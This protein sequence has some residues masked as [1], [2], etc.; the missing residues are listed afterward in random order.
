M[1]TGSILDEIRA[2][3]EAELEAEKAAEGFGSIF[4]RAKDS[5]PRAPFAAALRRAAD[6]T[7]AVIAE[8]K[9]ASP[10][11]GLIRADFEPAD[12]AESLAESG[13]A[14]LSVLTEKNFFLGGPE[15][16]KA[17]ARA[18]EIPLLRKDFIFDRYQICQAKAWGASAVL[19]IAAM[20]SREELAD[21]RGFAESLGLDALCEAHTEAELDAAVSSGAKIVGVNSRNLKTF[22]TDLDGAAGLLKLVPE[23]LLR[24]CESAVDSRGALLKAGASGADAALVGTELMRSPSPARRLGELLGRGAQWA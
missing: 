22:T 12:L 6:G 11:V 13:A 16:L 21:L 20:L 8:L 2:R 7:P 14:A 10:S 5:P 1:K 23:S 3:K 4:A 17:A 19:L 24:V 9:K 18:V 15:N